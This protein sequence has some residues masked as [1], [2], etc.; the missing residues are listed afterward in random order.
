MVSLEFL[1]KESVREVY[2]IAIS[3]I[4][5]F[6]VLQTTGTALNTDQPVVSVVS[7]SMY[8]QLHV[9]DVLVVNGV[10]YEKIETGDIVVFSVKQAEV[11]VDGQDHSLNGHTATNT[12]LGE[13]TVLSVRTTRS[14]QAV[15]GTIE[16]N[17][18][19]LQVVE[20]ET[21]SVGG[22][23][24]EVGEIEGDSIPIVHRVIE[25]NEDFVQTKGDN[26]NRQLSFE[27]RVEPEQIHGNVLFMVPRIGGVKL[28]AMDLIGYQ[29]DAP[30]VL[31]SY[32]RCSVENEYTPG[33]YR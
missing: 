12:S 28:L 9:G 27:S 20:G 13:A 32:P 30:L 11:T 33:Q 23:T 21:Y 2:F 19:R 14:G 8:P 10:D 3:L 25:K 5:A 29:G 16:F 7:C 1:E 6:G 31:D 22:S 26:N 17:G 18:E 15:A 4:L 24:V